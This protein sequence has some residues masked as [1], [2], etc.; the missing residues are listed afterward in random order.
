MDTETGSILLE[1]M[2]FYSG[3][4]AQGA[5]VSSNPITRLKQVEGLLTSACSS[6]L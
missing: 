4:R 2:R 1:S 3:K 6:Y 5:V